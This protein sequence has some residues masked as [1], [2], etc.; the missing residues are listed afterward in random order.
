MQASRREFNG[1]RFERR[2]DDTAPSNTPAYS[3]IQNSTC[4]TAPEVTEGPY[5]VA[6][7]LLRTDLHGDQ[8]GVDLVLD[9]GVMDTTTCTPLDNAL[10]TGAYAGFTTATL[11]IPDGTGGGPIQST[12]MGDQYTWLR[13]GYATNSEG[14]VGFK[15]IYPGHWETG[16]AFGMAS[17][18]G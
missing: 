5:Y 11:G 14:I 16:P 4:V 15:T 8:A 12:T 6:N 2:Q 17:A 9:I 1:G 10:A 7:E 18:G 3:I 13:G